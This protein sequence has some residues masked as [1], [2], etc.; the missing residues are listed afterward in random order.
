MNV[1]RR[2]VAALAAGSSLA[3]AISLAGTAGA[4]E[5]AKR[6]EDNRDVEVVEVD[7]PRDRDRDAGRIGAA[8]ATW[9]NTR[10]TATNTRPTW[11]NTRPTWTNTG[12][13]VT[14]TGVTGATDDRS[15][16]RE[17]RDWTTDG[18]DGWTRDLTRDLTDDRS[19][20][21]TR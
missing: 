20:N 6:A 10:P 19:R 1:R 2:T 21:N 7:D 14:N 17:V 8:D 16:G 3:L 15:R 18:G 9:T 5:V 13:S 12:P 4:T 11:T